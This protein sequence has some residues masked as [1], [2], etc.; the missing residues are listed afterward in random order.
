MFKKT[1]SFYASWPEFSIFSTYFD[2]EHNVT[3]FKIVCIFF[4]KTDLFRVSSLLSKLSSQ[5]HDLASSQFK[6]T[7][8]FSKQTTFLWE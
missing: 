4:A 3:I 1:F 6:Q 7:T 5:Y 2:E 8:H